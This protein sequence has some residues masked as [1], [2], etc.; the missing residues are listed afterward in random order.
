MDDKRS[1]CACGAYEGDKHAWSCPFTYYGHEWSAL[2]KWREMH[3]RVVL[4]EWLHQRRR[5]VADMKL[6]GAEAYI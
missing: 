2:K 1:V 4:N 5:R 3:G 6:T